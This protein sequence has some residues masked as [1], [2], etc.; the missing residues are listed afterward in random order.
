MVDRGGRSRRAARRPPRRQ[1]DQTR[2]PAIL[3][4]GKH[5]GWLVEFRLDN[6]ATTAAM[7]R[8]GALGELMADLRLLGM[9][10]TVIVP[11]D[12][13]TVELCRS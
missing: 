13:S 2:E 6:T 5:S 1:A 12:S 4:A 8:R 11:D 10:P 3:A 7:L 9:A